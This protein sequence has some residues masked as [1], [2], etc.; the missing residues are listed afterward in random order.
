MVGLKKE[1][2]YEKLRTEILNGTL[3]A[4]SK[5]PREV[6]LSQN[7]GISRVTLRPALKRLEQEG[8]IQRLH[9][10]GTYV[11]PESSH[12][13]SKMTILVISAQNSGVHQPQNFI[14]PEIFR[15]AAIKNYHV[16]HFDTQSVAMSSPE[17]FAKIATELNTVAIISVTNNYN[18]DEPT[19][20]ILKAAKCPVLLPHG[21]ELDHE[22]TGFT[23]FYTSRRLSWRASL[24]YLSQQG[25]N[26]IAQLGNIATSRPFRNYTSSQAVKLTEELGLDC[27]PDLFAT[28]DIEDINSIKQVVASWLNLEK[29]PEAILCFSDF[30]AFHFIRELKKCGISIPH[31]IAIMGICGAPDAAIM[32]PPL[33]SIDYCYSELAEQSVELIA[34]DNL[35]QPGTRIKHPFILRERASVVKKN[36][37][38]NIA[39]TIAIKPKILQ[40]EI[41]L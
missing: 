34:S 16:E 23:T 17:D 13:K 39:K 28:A 36:K 6:N 9:G 15:F 18:G 37:S 5:L 2:V 1:Q 35:P 8:Y 31:D 30:F 3:S 38:N 26:R 27:D 12:G 7:L 22:V 19:I 24:E 41:S 10:R 4:G 29:R 21:A 11:M 14:V 25:Y 33:T 32:N 20:D 40:M